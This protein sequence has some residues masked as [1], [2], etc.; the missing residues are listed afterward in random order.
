MELDAFRYVAIKDYNIQSMCVLCACACNEIG[1]YQFTIELLSFVQG[2]IVYLVPGN[3]YLVFFV[4]KK[5]KGFA[6]RAADA[7]NLAQR[8]IQRRGQQK[9]PMILCN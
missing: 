9:R 4:C 3:R 8:R 2:V 7:A 5:Y 6:S 1:N